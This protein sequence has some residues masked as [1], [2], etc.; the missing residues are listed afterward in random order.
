MALGPPSLSLCRDKEELEELKEQ[1]W[2][3]PLQD[4]EGLWTWGTPPWCDQQAAGRGSEA[5]GVPDVPRLLP[6]APVPELSGSCAIR[7]ALGSQ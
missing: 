2:E 5:L 3:L 1:N 7:G 6:R 4:G